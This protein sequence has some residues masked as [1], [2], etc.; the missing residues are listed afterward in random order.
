MTVPLLDNFI[1]LHG[2]VHV[3]TFDFDLTCLE[4]LLIFRVLISTM[5]NELLY[6]LME[7]HIT[8]K[9][10]LINRVF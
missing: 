2:P 8:M 3:Q 10:N 1:R 9:G 5:S 6:P 7:I 4:L